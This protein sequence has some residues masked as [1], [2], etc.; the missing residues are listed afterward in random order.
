MQRENRTRE[1]TP[2]EDVIVGR[3]AVAEALRSGREIDRLLVAKGAAGG[4][5]SVLIAKARE[6]GGMK[7]I[8]VRGKARCSDTG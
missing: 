3:N 1:Q 5:V 8:C 2:F 7:S 6:Q 4:S